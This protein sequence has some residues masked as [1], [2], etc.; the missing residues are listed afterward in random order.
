VSEVRY[1]FTARDLATVARNIG[2][3]SAP[4]PDTVLESIA[5]AG[6]HTQVQAAAGL[7]FSAILTARPFGADSIAFAVEATRTFLIANGVRITRIVDPDRA[8]TLA[9][10]V[11]SHTLEGADEIGKRLIA[12]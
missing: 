11:R 5:Q 6:D 9:E 4:E 8:V 2:I 3:A 10:A 7:L 12:L 1:R